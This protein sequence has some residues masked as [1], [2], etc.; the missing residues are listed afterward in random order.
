MSN[1]DGRVA[2]WLEAEKK[3]FRWYA[4]DG[5]RKSKTIPEYDSLS[6]DQVEDLRSTWQITL[7]NGNVDPFTGRVVTSRMTLSQLWAH[8]QQNEFENLRGNSA[9]SYELI[10]RLYIEP[11]WGTITLSAVKTTA[12]ERWLRAVKLRNGNLASKEYKAK[13][14]NV[15]SA[16]F[17]HALREDFCSRNPISCGGSDIGHGGKRGSGAGVRLLGEFS[18][19]RLIVHFAPEQVLAILAELSHR[20]CALVLLDAVLGLRRGE[21][22]GL[23]WSDCRFE[24]NCFVIRHSFDWRTGEENPPKTEASD[25][26]LPMHPVLK[27]ALLAW[28][29]QTPYTQPEDYVFPSQ[30]LRGR[31]PVALKDVFVRKIK[32]IIERLG[33][34]DPGAHYGWHSFRHSVGTALWDLTRDELTVRDL[35]RHS[36]TAIC[37]RYMHGIRPRMIDGQDKLVAAIGIQPTRQPPPTSAKVIRMPNRKKHR[38]SAAAAGD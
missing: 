6:K 18:E 7:N 8:Y 12:V 9:A 34:A 5:T 30:R 2:V 14:R 35:L 31:K 26:K 19:K 27:D 22:G 38:L 28:R 24:L 15:M 11:R 10:W 33:L 16:M 37:D 1:S 3:R 17:S 29:E 13:I 4:P 23:H 36:R 20:D 32:P 21:L 25:A